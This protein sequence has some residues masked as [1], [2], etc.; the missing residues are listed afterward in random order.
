MLKLIFGVIRCSCVWDTNRAIHSNWS[1]NKALHVAKDPHEKAAVLPQTLLF[2][3][4]N[5]YLCRGRTSA[6]GDLCEPSFRGCVWLLQATDE[7]TMWSL[8]TRTLWA[9]HSVPSHGQRWTARGGQEQ[10]ECNMIL[11]SLIFS[12][13]LLMFSSGAPRACC[14]LSFSNQRAS[15]PGTLPSSLW[16]HEAPPKHHPLE[17][18]SWA[19]KLHHCLHGAPPPFDPGLFVCLPVIW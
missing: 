19:P 1:P 8:R 16:T 9:H 10:H 13:L 6:R 2:W 11:L 18:T 15:T 12:Q 4:L 7:V 3:R 5:H 14:T 17:K